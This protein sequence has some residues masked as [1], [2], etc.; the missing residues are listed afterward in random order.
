[1]SAIGLSLSGG[2]VLVQLTQLFPKAIAIPNGVLIACWYIALAGVV[3]KVVGS[4]MVSYYA[5]DDED[6]QAVKATLGPV[7]AIP[8]QPTT[9]P[10]KAT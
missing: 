3:L 7:P 6:L 1:M 5:A 8:P 10:P 9:E 2:G 4:A